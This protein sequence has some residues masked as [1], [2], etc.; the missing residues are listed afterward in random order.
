[1][2]GIFFIL[3]GFFYYKLFA[4]LTSRLSAKMYKRDLNSIVGKHSLSISPDGI[5]DN[6]EIGQNTI[7]WKGVVLL[8]SNER[9]LFVLNYGSNGIIVPKRAFP[10][11]SSFNQFVE[12][13]K[14]YY[15]SATVAQKGS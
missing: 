13:A 5:T 2:M 3:M 8:E 4:T 7:K 9:Y 1:M 12:T 6:N 15:Q 14:S 10:D 11:E